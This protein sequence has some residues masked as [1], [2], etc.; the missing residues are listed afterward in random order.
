MAAAPDIVRVWSN[1]LVQRALLHETFE[2]FR[3]IDDYGRRLRSGHLQDRIDA[4]ALESFANGVYEVLLELGVQLLLADAAEDREAVERLT[5]EALLEV[6]LARKVLSKAQWE[7]LDEVRLGRNDLTHRA[8]F[9]PWKQ[10][11][12]HVELIEGSIDKIMA[13]FQ[14]NFERVQMP[15]DMDFP[16]F[17]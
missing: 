6:L 13:G 12:R 7:I 14:E 2:R 5:R 10:V 1:L 16:E 8:S 4:A 3:G 15:L 17:E 9:V 11:W